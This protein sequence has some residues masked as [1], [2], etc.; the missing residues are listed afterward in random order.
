MSEETAVGKYIKECVSVL[1]TMADEVKS[2][3][4]RL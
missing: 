1:R 2:E 4:I 3:G